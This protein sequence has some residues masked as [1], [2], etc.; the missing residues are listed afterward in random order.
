MVAFLVL[1]A[2][3]SMFFL[4]WRYGREQG[5]GADWM[6]SIW[7]VAMVASYAMWGIALL[8]LVVTTF[9]GADERNR[10]GPPPP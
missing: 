4:Y 9:N 3:N 5:V 8:I 7:P 10:F 6:S 1:L 2:I